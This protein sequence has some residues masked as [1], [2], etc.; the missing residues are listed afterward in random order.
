MED[1]FSQDEAVVGGR[2]GEGGLSTKLCTALQRTLLSLLECNKT[3][4]QPCAVRLSPP[5][6]V[7]RIQG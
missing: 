7:L 6:E 3:S 1:D 4:W 5:E 2:L